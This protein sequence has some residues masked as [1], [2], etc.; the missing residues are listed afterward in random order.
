M[1]AD[2]NFRGD[3]S[4]ILQIRSATCTNQMVA[5]RTIMTVPQFERPGGCGDGATGYS[6]AAVTGNPSRRN[7]IKSGDGVDEMKSP[8]TNSER[9]MKMEWTE[10]AYLL[11]SGRQPGD[12]VLLG[13][14][15]CSCSWCWPRGTS[16]KLPLAVILVVPM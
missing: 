15:W 2:P 6:A 12:V 16:W 5:A 8:A 13:W 9:G 1:Q 11:K 10:L 7:R 3:A 4:D 14:R